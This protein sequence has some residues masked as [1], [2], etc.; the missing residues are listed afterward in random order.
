VRGQREVAERMSGEKEP[1]LAVNSQGK[2]VEEWICFHYDKQT[3]MKGIK[4]NSQGNGLGGEEERS[5]ESL[6]VKELTDHRNLRLIL[7]S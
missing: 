7:S 1:E 6:T 4:L 5:R 2:R 3:G